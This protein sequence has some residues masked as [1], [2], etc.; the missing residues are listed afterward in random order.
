MSDYDWVRQFAGSIVLCDREGV[1]LEM[2]DKA[3]EG[4]RE[5]G[6]RGLVGQNLFDCHPEPSRSRL[7]QMMDAQQPNVYTVE[8]HGTKKLVYQTPWY[9]SGAYAGFIEVV[10]EIPW[11]V[12]HF[13]R[14]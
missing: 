13:V 2:N 7:R 3:A 12:P 8:K 5:E 11:Q 9:Q 10:L 14:D 1:V 4:Y 6:G